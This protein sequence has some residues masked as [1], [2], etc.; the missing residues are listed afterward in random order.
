[1]SSHECG[2]PELSDAINMLALAAGKQSQSFQSLIPLC[3]AASRSNFKITVKFWQLESS[4]AA[5]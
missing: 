2:M 4:N 5:L 1:M 3:M